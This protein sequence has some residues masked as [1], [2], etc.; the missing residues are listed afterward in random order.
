[1]HGDRAA[2]THGRFVDANPGTGESWYY[3]RV[4]QTDRNLAWSSSIWVKYT[5][6]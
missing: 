5:G 2:A 1:M 6:R 3:V 4:A